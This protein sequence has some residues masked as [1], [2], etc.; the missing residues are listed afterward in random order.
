MTLC[1]HC[2]MLVAAARPCCPRCRRW[3]PGAHALRRPA[4]EALAFAGVVGAMGLM[5]AATLGG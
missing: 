3:W 1:K 4:L 2:S 5:V